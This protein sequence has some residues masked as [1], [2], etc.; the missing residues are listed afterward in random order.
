MRKIPYINIGKNKD[1]FMS[2]GKICASFCGRKLG[3]YTKKELVRVSESIGK[4][5]VDL[6]RTGIEFSKEAVEAT[7][8]KHAPKVKLNL[9]TT[10]AELKADLM[11]H[12]ATEKQA[13]NC[14]AMID[15]A[16]AVHYKYYYRDGKTS[17]IFAPLSEGLPATFSHEFA[18]QLFRQ[19]SFYS[20]IFHKRLDN[21][22]FP[23]N[24]IQ[25]NIVE[26]IDLSKTSF[27]DMLAP[28][29]SLKPGKENLI[30]YLQ[31]FDRLD[32]PKRIRAL[33]SGMC[34]NVVHHKNK[35]AFREIAGARQIIQDESRAYGITDR[36]LHYQLGNSEAP[37][38]A[39]GVFS[40]FLNYADDVL[41]Q[42]QKLSLLTKTSKTPIKRS[43]PSSTYELN[44]I[45]KILRNR[46]R[47]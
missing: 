9:Q 5:L 14:L 43:C 11:K 15:D 1:I 24:N 7:V 36:V 42:E 19:N 2:L 41:K 6:Q 31:N 21:G 4:D 8:K 18:H 29:A 10:P 30:N 37:M 39:S 40:E 46:Q 3:L 17:G 27:D 22:T 25:K 35:G 34:R 38:T 47:S 28:V 45:E 26:T 44:I 33:F 20:K 32:T 16:A 23:A 13:D 12:G